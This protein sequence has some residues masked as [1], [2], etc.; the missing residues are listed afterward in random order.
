[1]CNKLASRLIRVGLAN[2][3]AVP[4]C[5]ICENTP[6][7]FYCEIDGTSL[8]L[9]CDMIVHVGGKRTHGRYLLLRQRVEFPGDKPAVENQQNDKASLVQGINADADG[10]LEMDTEMIDLNMKP[11]RI[12][13]QASNN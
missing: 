10:H 11:H 13:E 2:P 7:F 4:R 12:H 3:T 5:D 8:C 6:A 9:Q 1:M